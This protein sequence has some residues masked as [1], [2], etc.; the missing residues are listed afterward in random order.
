MVDNAE[1]VVSR[2]LASASRQPDAPAIINERRTLTYEEF[3]RSVIAAAGRLHQFGVRAGDTVAVTLGAD[4]D[5]AGLGS[6]LYGVGYLGATVLPLYPDFPPMR[7]DWLA[8]RFG[9]KWLVDSSRSAP[10]PGVALLTLE[11]VM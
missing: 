10:P 1:S 7:C 9:A 4:S 6:I 2:L 11:Q 3:S 8:Q 5:A